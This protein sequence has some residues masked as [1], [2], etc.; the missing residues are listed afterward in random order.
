[1]KQHMWTAREVA[2]YYG[3]TTRTIRRWRAI[4]IVPKPATPPGTHPRWNPADITENNRDTGGH[5]RTNA[6]PSSIP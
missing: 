5:G 2:K 6:P 1:M 4:G 3:V